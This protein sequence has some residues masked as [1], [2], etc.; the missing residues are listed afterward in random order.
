MVRK[1]FH[2]TINTLKAKIT[3]SVRTISIVKLPEMDLSQ[4]NLF[5]NILIL[6][7]H[8]GIMACIG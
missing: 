2:L 6:A 8:W 5:D 1:I 3:N 4:G 7:K